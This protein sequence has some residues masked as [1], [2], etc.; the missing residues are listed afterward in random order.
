MNLFKNCPGSKSIRTPFPEEIKCVCG[1][2]TEIWSD[3]TSAI[4]KKCRRRVTR[5]MLP[6]CLDW[7]SQAREC[8]GEVKF[9]K[10]LKAKKKTGIIRKGGMNHACNS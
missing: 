10:Y 3:E 5:D 2:M 8:V 7:C 4:C 6:N 1:G 9:K